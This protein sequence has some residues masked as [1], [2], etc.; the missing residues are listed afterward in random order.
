MAKNFR[1]DY[2][3]K[4]TKARKTTYEFSN[5]MV[6]DEDI[7]KI[8]E[9]GRWAPSC[10]NT[11]PWHFII[12]KD[13]EKIS[14]LIKTANYGDF[15]TEPNRIIALILLEDRCPGKG[16]LCVRGKDSGVHDSYMGLGMAGLNMTLEAKDLGID[17]CILTPEQIMVKKIL[18][19]RESD[20][21]PLL[22][23]LGYQDKKAFQK[24]RERRELSEIISYEY[25]GGKRWRKKSG[26]RL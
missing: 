13:K 10:T 4:L 15:H 9:A 14:R 24:K 20:A 25:F 2:F 1:G 6:N 19:I 17:S 5:R 7:K 23:G 18:K 16:H 8:L 3:L 26:K 22:I 12:V 11:Q 21:V